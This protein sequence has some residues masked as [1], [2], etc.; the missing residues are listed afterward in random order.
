M[1]ASSPKKIRQ[2]AQQHGS[3]N[4]I[5]SQVRPDYETAFVPLRE[6]P[7]SWAG[8]VMGFLAQRGSTDLALV[9]SLAGLVY[10]GAQLPQAGANL[11]PLGLTGTLVVALLLSA[12]SVGSLYW[13][14][15]RNAK[16]AEKQS[17]HT[18]QLGD[19]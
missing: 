8:A 10:I 12:V 14:N 5:A 15:R 1:S 16:A 9:G 18:S 2:D 7:E 6:R 11:T 17:V 3:K 4:A 13:G 19:G